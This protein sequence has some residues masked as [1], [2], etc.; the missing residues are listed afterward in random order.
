MF[1]LAYYGMLR[2]G[3][4]TWSPHTV[5]ACNIHVGN[6]KDK[7]LIVLYTSKTHGEESGPQKV[8]ISALPT[9]QTIQRF[10]CPFNL[11]I[12]YMQTRGPYLTEQESFF[13]FSDRTSVRADQFRS[14]LRTLLN[15][16]NLDGSLYDVHS[17]RSGRTCDLAK[18]GY[19]VVQIKAMGRWK[20]NAVYRYLK[21]LSY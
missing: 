21:N 19:S 10:F 11:V 6:N 12:S 17:F 18:F 9:K 13:V 3:E 8:K 1:C 7:I 14:L 16:L 20:S 5:K 15:K 4:I 2:V